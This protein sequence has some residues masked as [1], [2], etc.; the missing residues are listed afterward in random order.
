MA[1][2]LTRPVPVNVP[3]VL[4]KLNGGATTYLFAVVTVTVGVPWH[5]VQV[6]LVVVVPQVTVAADP[7]Q[8]LVEQVP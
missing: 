8:V 4:A 7:W 5:L 1:L 3:V 6:S 2:S